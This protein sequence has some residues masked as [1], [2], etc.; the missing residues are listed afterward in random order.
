MSRSA[1]LL[2]KCQPV[3]KK[4]SYICCY[5]SLDPPRYFSQ[6]TWIKASWNKERISCKGC[7]CPWTNWI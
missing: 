1:I 5:I 7:V 2:P 3:F 4:T 6:P